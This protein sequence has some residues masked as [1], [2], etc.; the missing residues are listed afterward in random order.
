LP[1]TSAPEVE[2]GQ[3]NILTADELSRIERDNIRR[4]LDQTSWQVAGEHGAARILGMA[5]STLASRM[6]ALGL[7]KPS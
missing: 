6:K 4:A 5:P 1:V 7:R 2:P 3:A